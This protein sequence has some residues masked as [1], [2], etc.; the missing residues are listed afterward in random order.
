MKRGEKIKRRT[1]SMRGLSRLG[2]TS[3]N[4]RGDVWYG[5]LKT[6]VGRSPNTSWSGLLLNLM[7]RKSSWKVNHLA[8][9]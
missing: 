7:I 3:I 2:G 1:T 4:F 6:D 5:L 9:V 8:Q